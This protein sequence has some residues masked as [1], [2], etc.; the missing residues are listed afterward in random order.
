MTTFTILFSLIIFGSSC[1]PLAPG[2][3]AYRPLPQWEAK[4]AA[5]AKKDIYPNDVRQRPASYTNTLVVWTGVIT[6]ITTF[7]E[8]DKRTCRITADH[9]YFDWVEDFGIP[10][11]RFF[12]SPRGEGAFAAAWGA[13]SSQ[14]EK[15]LRQFVVGDMLVAYGY[16][17]LIRS[18]I[19][20]LY[21]TENLRAIKPQ[22][23]STNIESRPA[24]RT[25]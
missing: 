9:H 12:L 15:F 1:V 10:P 24:R 7:G 8:G 3:R 6:N 5:E 2:S 23:Y 22:W 4:F 18:N 25:C 21:P 17:S 11:Q 19:V 13:V 20:G 16:P 14:D